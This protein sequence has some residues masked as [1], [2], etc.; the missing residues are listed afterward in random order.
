VIE[1]NKAEDNEIESIYPSDLYEGA[2]KGYDYVVKHNISDG[3]N[4]KGQVTREETWV[5]IERFANSL[6]GEV[7]IPP[8]VVVPEIPKF[9]VKS[10]VP[11]LIRRFE[12]D[13]HYFKT[14]KDMSVKSTLGERFKKEAVSKIVR[15]HLKDKTILGINAGFFG[16]LQASESMGLYIANGLY[17][18]PPNPDFLEFIHYKDGTTEITNMQEYDMKVLSSIQSTSHWAIGASYSLIQDGRINLQNKEKFSHYKNREPRT[19]IG[20]TI[21]GSFILAVADGRRTDSKGITAQQQSEIMMELG[22]EIAVNL[23]GGGSSTFVAVE[24]GDVKVLNIPS[25]G[26]KERLV[27]SVFIVQNNL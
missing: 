3:K 27:G 21:D 17:Y 13:I 14:T 7:I 15:D 8:E 24:N 12:S 4:P 26:N 16:Y 10:G 6:S 25:D 20:Q 22:C 23:D 9:I 5:M 11:Q 2:R 19:M 1:Q 18:N